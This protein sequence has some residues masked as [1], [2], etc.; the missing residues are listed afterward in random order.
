V[1]LTT[2]PPPTVQANAKPIGFAGLYKAMH[3]A[4]IDSFAYLYQALMK[5]SNL[6]ALQCSTP[7]LANFSNIDSSVV[8]PTT[9]PPE[10][11]LTPMNLDSYAKA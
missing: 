1:L 9:K 6:E 5:V 2:F 11:R 7:P 4:E 8:T 10:T 3:P